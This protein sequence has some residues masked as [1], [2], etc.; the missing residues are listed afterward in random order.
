MDWLTVVAIAAMATSLSIGFHEGVHA[1]VCVAVGGQVKE[2]SSFQVHF[3]VRKA[4]RKRVVTGSASVANILLGFLTLVFL[5]NS[6]QVPELQFFLWLFMLM[7]FLYG[8]GDWMSSGM[9]N[10][11]D[12]AMVIAGWKPHWFWRLGLAVG[13]SIIFMALIWLS[14]GQFGQIVG[15]SEPELYGRAHELAVISYITAPLVIIIAGFFSPRG[16]MSLPVVF[17]LAATLGALSPLLWMMQWFRSGIFAK[18][19]GDPLIIP[20]NWVM[21]AA[22]VIVVAGYAVLFNKRKLLAKGQPAQSELESS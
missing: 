3:V 19:G 1:A 6:S 21:M 2:F 9:T 8:S 20:R 5:R 17:A 11:G 15:G 16:F 4:W 7:N 14:L 13:G 18:A 12:W 22:A 10:H